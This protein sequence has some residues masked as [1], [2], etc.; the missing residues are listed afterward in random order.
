MAKAKA[1]ITTPP[2]IENMDLRGYVDYDEDTYETGIG[3]DTY[4]HI[5][6]VRLVSAN[7]ESLAK[8]LTT[9][10]FDTYCVERILTHYG[11][12]DNGK[13]TFDVRE[14]YYG[15]E[16]FGAKPIYVQEIG[17]TI[18]SC[19]RLSDNEKI[20]FILELEYGYLLNEVKNKSWSIRVVKR[21]DIRF[22]SQ[23]H[24]TEP[25]E[26]YEEYKLPVCVTI[27]TPEG[28]TIIDG[29]HRLLSVQKDKFSVI[30][31]V[32]LVCYYKEKMNEIS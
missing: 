21:E 13:W 16:V 1:K 19:L 5:D 2:R 17:Q 25:V 24:K 15:D 32:Q 12:Y 29:Y 3:H 4:T 27:D 9:T 18:D 23:Y 22:G 11:L 31:G 7:L 28:L 26:R 20:P 6:G 8:K 14:Y 10:D 30:V